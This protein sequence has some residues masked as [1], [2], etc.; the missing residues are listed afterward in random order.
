MLSYRKQVKFTLGLVYAAMVLVLAATVFLP[1]FVTWYVEAKGRDDSLPTVIMLTVY[2]CVPF[3]FLALVSLR[4]L[5]LNFLDGLVLGDANIKALK[6]IV[7][8]CF[9]AAAIT[10]Y[11]GH[12]YLPFYF[13][14]AAAAACGLVIAVIRSMLDCALQQ[15]RE[16][17]YKSIREQYDENSNFSNR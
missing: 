13:A 4:R 11:S 2:P 10:L 16:E 6:R 12:L 7:I 5:L 14:A 17:E 9:I 8:C 1:S 15:K 3:A